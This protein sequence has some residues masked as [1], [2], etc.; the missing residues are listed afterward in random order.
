MRSD[1]SVTTILRAV[2]GLKPTSSGTKTLGAE[3]RHFSAT[4]T[5]YGTV[6]TTMALEG[7]TVYVNNPFALLR[8]TA[9][10]SPKLSNFFAAPSGK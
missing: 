6:A 7:H 2:T 8:A 1:V 3:F 4:V 9:Q 10:L 5:P